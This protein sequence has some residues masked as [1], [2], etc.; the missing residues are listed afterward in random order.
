MHQYFDRKPLKWNIEDFLKECASKTM[1]A[2]LLIPSHEASIEAQGDK[3]DCKLANKCGFSCKSEKKPS[4]NIQNT[5]TGGSQTI[6]TVNDRTFITELSTSKKRSQEEDNEIS[7]RQIK[8]RKTESG[9]TILNYCELSDKK[10]NEIKSDLENSFN[11]EYNKMKNHLKWKLKSTGRVVEDTLYECMSDFTSEH[12]IHS[13]TIDIDDPIIK[14][15]F[16]PQELQEIAKTNVKE[17]PDLSSKLY[18]NLEFF[19]NKKNNEKIDQEEYDF[20]VDTL[21]YSVHSLARQYERNP[22]AFSLDHYEAWYNVNVWGPIVDRTFDDIPNVDIARGESSSHASSDRKN[23]NRT[24]DTRKKWVE[25]AIIRKL[26]GEMRLE[27]GGSEAGK[28]Y[29]LCKITDWDPEKMEKMET[30]GYIHGLVLM[31]MTL[32]LPAGY[33]TR[34]NKSELYR[35][36][37]DIESFNDAIELITAVWK[38]KMR[39]V[40]TMILL[41]NKEKGVIID[42]LRNVSTI[43]R[44][45]N[46][47]T[48]QI[49]KIKKILPENQ[50]TPEKAKKKDR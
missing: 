35:I 16:Y 46:S 28:R 23:R 17:D 2:N 26:S 33:V 41:N 48:N 5:F 44:N 12:L 7:T 43:K 24:M 34:I 25:D 37:E 14:G 3:I 20:E 32:D 36:P 42:R 40:N 50:T 4:I 21:K 31:I 18:E 15:I 11:K 19:C 6:G 30:V 49:N 38:S 22:S 8:P 1:R 13:F 27:F 10:E 9:E 45:K 39:V 29:D 47:H